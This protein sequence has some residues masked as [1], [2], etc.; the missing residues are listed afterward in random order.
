MRPICR[1]LG[2]LPEDQLDEATLLQ[3]LPLMKKQP[4]YHVGVYTND[5]VAVKSG[6]RW[7]L[8]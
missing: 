6:L 4:R 2:E 5:P 3:F 1:S 8:S 7:V